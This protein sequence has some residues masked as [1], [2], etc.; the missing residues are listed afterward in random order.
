MNANEKDVVVLIGSGQIGQA[1][2]RRVGSGRHIVLADLKQEHADQAARVLENTGFTTSTLPSI[3]PR[4][5]P[6]WASSITPNSSALLN[7]SSTLPACRRLRPRS[8]RS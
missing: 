1:I 6:F 5:R 8:K 7:T 2:A 3:F 4:V